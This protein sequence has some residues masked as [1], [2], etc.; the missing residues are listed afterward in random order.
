M[1]FYLFLHTDTI[2]RDKTG[3]RR[4]LKEEKRLKK[5]EEAKKAEEDEKFLEWGKG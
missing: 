2:F 1:S 3:R 4:D 5:E